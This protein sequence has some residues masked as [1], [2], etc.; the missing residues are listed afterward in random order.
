MKDPIYL[1]NECWQ[2][3][4]HCFATSY[5]FEQRVLRLRRRLRLLT[6]LG[7]ATPATVGAA[8]A[9]YGAK[10]LITI[11]LVAIA[12]LLGVI[13]VVFSAWSLAFK[14]DDDFAYSLGAQSANRAL[15]D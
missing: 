2:Q 7:I 12:S 15:F 8:Y 13:Q 1:R 6:F 10:S 5:I 11:V 3:A 9:T 14:W 4:V